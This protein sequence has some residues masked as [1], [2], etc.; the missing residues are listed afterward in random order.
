MFD[1]ISALPQIDF[2]ISTELY[3]ENPYRILEPLFKSIH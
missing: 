1:G 3:L 2:S